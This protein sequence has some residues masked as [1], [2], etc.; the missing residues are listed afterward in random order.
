MV[1]G[2]GRSRGNEGITFLTYCV[3][4]FPVR[5][6][7]KCVLEDSPAIKNR[8]CKSHGTLCFFLPLPE[9]R[10]RRVLDLIVDFILTKTVHRH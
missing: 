6:K 4:G 5:H 7:A 3:D 1:N 2:E 9:S 10:A 8:R